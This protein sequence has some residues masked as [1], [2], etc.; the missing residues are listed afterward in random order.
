MFPILLL[1][2]K[3]ENRFIANQTENYVHECKSFCNQEGAVMVDAELAV[4]IQHF[5]VHDQE[6][7]HSI[8]RPKLQRKTERLH[9]NVEYDFRNQ[10]WINA[11][12]KT[13]FNE[14]LWLRR[15][16]NVPF[17]P[18]LDDLLGKSYEFTA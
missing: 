7:R 2:L 4:K 16:E 12:T 10:R 1:L 5:T 9:L 8:T 11:A 14:S 17:F 18:L 13:E 6:T 15:D 3:S